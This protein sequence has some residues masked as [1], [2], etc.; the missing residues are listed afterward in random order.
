MA[1][2]CQ[3]IQDLRHQL[4]LRGDSTIP[5]VVLGAVPSPGP[6]EDHFQPL[7]RGLNVTEHILS[8]QQRNQ[9]NGT[10][11][12]RELL[13]QHHSSL[14]R[15]VSSW[16]HFFLGQLLYTWCC[17][18]HTGGFRKIL[19]MPM[20]SKVSQSNQKSQNRIPGIVRVSKYLP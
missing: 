20:P 1:D 9:T 5:D 4:S 16:T 6:S 12:L 2:G 18:G 14:S 10:L 3:Q 7:C 19:G 8:L 11:H 15:Q 17:A 13:A